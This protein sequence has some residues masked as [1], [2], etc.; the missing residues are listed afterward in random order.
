MTPDLTNEELTREVEGAAATLLEY[1]EDTI[2]LIEDGRDRWKARAQ[3]AEDDLQ[4][5][6]EEVALVRSLALQT[7]ALQ[8]LQPGW[9]GYGSGPVNLRALATVAGAVLAASPKA[10]ADLVPGG[11]GSVQAEWHLADVE[12]EFRVYADGTVSALAEDRRTGEETEFEGEDAFR[13]LQA[14]APRLANAHPT[15]ALAAL[16][17][18]RGGEGAAPL[19]GES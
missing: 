5:V 3:A 19:G 9:D 7:S 12:F 2:R 4:R 18:V 13:A 15:E 6:V 10:L 11:D 8:Q 1:I 14:W 16:S 17:S